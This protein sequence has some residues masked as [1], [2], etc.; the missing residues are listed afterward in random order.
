MKREELLKWF[1][2]VIVRTHNL[3]KSTRPH[4]S[5][6]YQDNKMVAEWLTEARSALEAAFPVG[7]AVRTNWEDLK[8]QYDVKGADYVT[9]DAYVDTAIGI[10]SSANS[11]LK[12]GYLTSLVDIIR[13]ETEAEL[14]DQA[15]IIMSNDWLAAAA[16]IAGGAL[17]SHLLHLCKRAGITWNGDGSISKYN[18]AI[19][20]AR[21]KGNEVYNATEGKLV[22]SWGG[23]RNEAAHSPGSFNRTKE[24]VRL[25][26]D[27]IRQFL[28]RVP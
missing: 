18:G 22:E 2:E 3:L 21:N 11:Q 24:E 1:E 23:I 7:H 20:E 25:M 19:G 14:I 16:V 27:G 13:N 4:E 15:E 26:I 5:S 10:F 9:Y 12:A 17:E 6:H 28:V 8:K